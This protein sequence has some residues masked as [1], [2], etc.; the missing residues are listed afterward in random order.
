MLT[1]LFYISAAPFTVSLTLSSITSH[2]GSGKD[3]YNLSCIAITP[4]GL[5]FYKEFVWN[6]I[7]GEKKAS[8]NVTYNNTETSNQY[9]SVSTSVYTTSFI[10]TATA[11][12]SCTV[13][14]YYSVDTTSE[15]NEIITTLYLPGV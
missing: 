8:I 7:S 5:A 11:L 12:A 1:S 6:I 9:G 14:L 2:G 15:A 13:K 4:Q 3:V 10:A